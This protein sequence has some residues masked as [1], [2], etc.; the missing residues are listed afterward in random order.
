MKGM[1]WLS[2]LLVI[3]LGLAW[4][5]RTW[6]HGLVMLF[7]TWPVILEAFVLWGLVHLLLISR[8]YF[9][10]RKQPVKDT[11]GNTTG[12]L[13]LAWLVSPFV[14]ILFVLVGSLTASFAR[15][16]YLA[17]TLNY[18]S[19]DRLPESKRSIRLM[20]RV[21]AYRYAQDSLQLSQYKLRS[22][23]ILVIDDGL[24]WAFPLSP[25]G[26][27]ISFLKKNHGIITVN[28]SRQDKNARLHEKTMQI[29]EGMQLTDNLW[30]NVYRHRYFVNAEEP[31]YLPFDGDVL[32]VVPAISYSLHFRWGVVYTA[33]HFAGLFV[34]NSAGDIRFLTPE[35]ARNEPALAGNRIFPEKLARTYIQAHRYRLG[36]INRLFIHEDQ[37]DLQDGGDGNEQPFLMMTEDSLKWFASAEPYGASHGVFKIFLVDARTGEIQLRELAA[38]ETLT[39][40]IRAIDYVRKSNPVVDWGRFDLVE[41]LPFVRNGV[42]YWKL[43]IIPSDAAGIAYQA[44]VDSR[45]NEVH[46][47]RSDDAITSF[48]RGE[49]AD[50]EVDQGTPGEADQ[51]TIID[52]VKEKLSEIEELLLR[53]EAS[54]R[55]D[56]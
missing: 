26:L 28:A 51:D 20:P 14:L 9:L 49:V 55:K 43:A 35:E 47:A 21:V 31:Y 19:I 23:N 36:V 13:K 22:D 30:W 44:F 48:I 54:G 18:Q 46:E 38:D 16:V 10:N 32:T 40:P 52:Q 25:D 33:P 56:R 11:S 45:T 5:F 39:G 15:Q 34:V 1:Y 29:G 42:L 7:Y 3:V 41:P 12:Y 37:I 2:I 17:R 4:F 24:H 8:S 50:F 27:V 53:L 6:L